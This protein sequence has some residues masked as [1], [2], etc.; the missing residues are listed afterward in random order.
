V[1]GLAISSIAACF[2]SPNIHSVDFA[3]FQPLGANTALPSWFLGF[4][5]A[6]PSLYA[7]TFA[8]H[9]ISLP[10]QSKRS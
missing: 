4:I 1:S 5:R 6:L 2:S 7:L 9:S 3:S 10:T 8:H